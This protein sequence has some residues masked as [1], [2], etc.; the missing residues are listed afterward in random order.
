[1][2][3]HEQWCGTVAPMGRA[4]SL[5]HGQLVGRRPGAPQSEL[6]PARSRT[7]ASGSRVNAERSCI[8]LELGQ[9]LEKGCEVLP[10]HKEVGRGIGHKCKATWEVPRRGG[11]RKG[12]ERN[13]REAEMLVMD[14]QSLAWRAT[15]T[16]EAAR[17][18]REI[19]RRVCFLGKAC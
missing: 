3:G 15:R 13:A 6:H 18:G 7:L 9:V 4:H 12:E 10:A 11:S 19:D 17:E 16:Q 2:R 5:H 8:T 14:C 1:M